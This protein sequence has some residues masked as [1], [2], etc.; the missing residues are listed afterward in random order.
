MSANYG[1]VSF[2]GLRDFPQTSFSPCNSLPDSP[3]SGVRCGKEESSSLTG[4][5]FRELAKSED[6]SLLNRDVER[7]EGSS[8][9][10]PTNFAEWRNDQTHIRGE[11]A[12]SH[13]MLG[14]GKG[15]PV[16]SDYLWL[17]CA[18]DRSPQTGSEVFSESTG[19]GLIA[20]RHLLQDVTLVQANPASA[21]TLTTDA[22]G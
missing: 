11:R 17:R 8:P 5:T 21:F 12:L 1:P 2:W 7:R 10:F 6:A 18:G 20:G 13:T 9:S 15:V 4:N 22:E 3:L 19:Y 16:R 14:T